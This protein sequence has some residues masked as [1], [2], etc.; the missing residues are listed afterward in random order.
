M[1]HRP[2]RS[3]NSADT[4]S[5]TVSAAA[6]Y[7]PLLRFGGSLIGAVTA[8]ALD[9]DSNTA[10]L[11]RSN[12]ENSLEVRRHCAVQCLPYCYPRL[13]HFAKHSEDKNKIVISLCDYT[14]KPTTNG[15]IVLPVSPTDLPCRSRRFHRCDFV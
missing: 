12:P 1:P 5:E 7:I 2:R 11:R 8:T 13:Q 10:E 9:L 4:R 15:D 14:K 6:R 3:G